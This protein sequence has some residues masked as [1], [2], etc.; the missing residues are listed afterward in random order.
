MTY[1]L[2][3]SQRQRGVTLIELMVTIVIT[4]FLV[5]AAAYVYLGTRETQRAIDRN[6]SNT[7]TGTFVLQLM[8]RDVMKGGYYPANI[9]RL[10][11]DEK[12][13]K[14][15][16]YLPYNGGQPTDWTSPTPQIAYIAGIYGCDG[17][18]YDPTA[19]LPCG[20]PSD[21]EPDS[22]VVNY[23]TND[24]M[25]V[26]AGD[27]FD[28]TGADVTNDVSTSNNSRRNIANPN[29]SPLQPLF[30]SNRY[31]LSDAKKTEIDG[32]E[33]TTRSLACVGNGS[34]D[35]AGSSGVPY[36]PMVQGIE[37]MQITYGIFGSTAA[38]ANLGRRTPDKYLTATQVSGLAPITIDLPM[39]GSTPLNGWSR[40]V[41][42]R[43]CVLAKSIGGSPKIAATSV[44]ERQYTDC[45][46]VVVTQD[47]GDKS[48][49]KRFVQ[50]FAVRNRLNQSY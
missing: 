29:L 37:D 38:T 41:S 48:L 33:V 7:E 16:G 45:K 6:G 2:H 10:T 20:T 40:V 39:L 12:Y 1:P 23:F 14:L 24:T 36:Q 44:A 21:N 13:P 30:V 34:G 9:T 25:N 28:C 11:P 3:T 49:R 4:M 43:I 35:N 31:A 8:G 32:Q 22:L 26:N 17:A 46:G 19:S 50:E 15:T 18:R 5:A 27:R 42:V 47:A